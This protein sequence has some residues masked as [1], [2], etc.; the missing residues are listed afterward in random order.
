MN[1]GI[2]VFMVLLVFSTG[3]FGE[4]VKKGEKPLKGEWNF[5]L[6]QE[7][8][9]ERAGGDILS[10][11]AYLQIARDG[12][13]YL[14][15]WKHQKFYIFDK[16]G[17][18][19]KSFGH[20]GEGPGEYKMVFAFF[21]QGDYLI[22]QDQMK[23]HYF[24]LNGVYV[25]SVNLKSMII[26]RAFVDENRCIIVKNREEQARKIDSVELLDLSSLTSRTVAEI[27]AEKEL[28]ASTNGKQV[29]LKDIF[30]T[31]SLIAAVHGNAIY[32]G[33][34][35]RYR[36]Y[37]ID[38]DGNLLQSFSLE[39]RQPKENPLQFKRRRF[40]NVRVN[41]KKMPEDMIRKMVKQMPDYFTYFT[42]IH[43]DDNGL[44]YVHVNDAANLHSE[45][46][47]IFAPD[48][49]Y[50]YHSVITLPEGLIRVTPFVIE[51][52][53]MVAFVED[54]DGEQ[55]LVKYRI[56]LPERLN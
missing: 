23:I 22:V 16:K 38:L 8:A 43:L 27:T 33:K 45:E 40:E 55:K 13:L 32:Y 18:F 7:W 19:I 51:Y 28:K 46:I 36:I 54:N 20:K 47:D 48:G 53:C 31:P 56:K 6:R 15:E 35:D 49:T 9:V 2:I 52:S 21:L 42:R 29:G 39:Q 37:K 11:I 1:C 30:T 34:N 24:N 12:R 14:F 25:K 3:G 41:N 5:D 17:M 44:I 50:L 4:D 10:Q 26:P